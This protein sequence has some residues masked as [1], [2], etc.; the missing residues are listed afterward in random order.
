MAE[1]DVNSLTPVKI[2][3]ELDRHIV[4]QSQAKRAVAIAL[5]NRW[6]RMRLDPAVRD[7]VIPKNILMIGP[8]GVGKTE[9]A[10]RLAKLV[11]APFLK[12][13][14]TKFT[15]VGYVGRDVESMIRDLVEVAVAQVKQR[16]Q[17]EVAEGAKKSTENRLLDLLVPPPS[18]G[19]AD[20]DSFRSTR[21]KFRTLLRSGALEDREVEIESRETRAGDMFAAMPGME[22]MEEGLR[23]MLSSLIPKRTRRRRVTVREARP[24]VENEEA[25]RLVDM[26]RVVP[27][28][29]ELVQQH[30]IIFLDELD[31]IAEPDS[32]SNQGNVS[33]QGVQRDLLPLVEGTTVTTRYGTVKTDHIL[34]IGA[35]A[36]STAKPSDLMAELQGRF[37]IRVELSSL[38]AE[39]FERIL[40][41]PQNNLLRQYALLLE[42]EG[43]RLEFDDGAIR[44]IAKTAAQVNES[45]DD[46]GARRLHTI[47]E[48][49]LEDL[50]FRAPELRGETVHI[51]ESYVKKRLQAVAGNRDLSRYIL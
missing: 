44:A 11:N 12:V 39:D 27:E 47:L 16:A 28:A 19:G 17:R 46:L 7:D 41:E 5:R 2:V 42:T 22:A 48:R 45:T 29:L 36:F 32:G 14:A 31:K 6:R 25:Q 24:I 43:V 38:D 33:R 4:G 40:R 15:E 13:E 50:S 21:E 35:G 30:G 26:D 23:E 3:E 18:F 20:D 49:L 1:W 8:T 10:R 37:P 51:D 34:F 9:I